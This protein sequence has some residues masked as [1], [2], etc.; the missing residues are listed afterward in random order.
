V[1]DW[2]QDAVQI[3]RRIRAFNPWPIAE[4][5]LEGTQLRIWESALPDAAMAQSEP[6]TVLAA[7][8]A[9]IDV[10]CGSGILRITRL[11]LAGRKPLFAGEFIKG[12]RLDGARFASA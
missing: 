10:A 5:R 9:G 12:Q 1:I 3:W 4:T 2:H 6:G 11:Q 7:T 8:N